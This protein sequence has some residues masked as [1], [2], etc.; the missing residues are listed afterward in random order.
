M[1]SGYWVHAPSRVKGDH[2]YHMAAAYVQVRVGARRLSIV[3]RSLILGYQGL[4]RAAG[5][6]ARDR[7]PTARSIALKRR[8]STFLGRVLARFRVRRC[9]ATATGY[10]T[11]RG[12][13][14]I[15][16]ASPRSRTSSMQSIRGGPC[17]LTGRAGCGVR[18]Y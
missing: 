1:E 9:P 6:D 16:S 18:G 3:A 10:S 7:H 12:G 13:H 15:I 5:Q 2:S 14:A 4:F 8:R 17:P 11:R